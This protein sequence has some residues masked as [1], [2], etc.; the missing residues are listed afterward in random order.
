[1]FQNAKEYIFYALEKK[2]A[3]D[4]WFQDIPGFIKWEERK[5]WKEK[6]NIEFM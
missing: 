6:K 5:T 2:C 1:M 4:P 3:A